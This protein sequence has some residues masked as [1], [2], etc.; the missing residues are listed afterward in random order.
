[1]GYLGLRP[2]AP[3]LL[4]GLRR[5]EYRGYDSAG[6]AV[7]D[8]A[9]DLRISKRVGKLETLIA[10]LQGETPEGSV[11]VGHPRWATHGRPSDDNAHPHLD[12]TGAVVVIH[13]G[14][15]ENYLS[16][17]RD[18]Q[19][20]GH[21]FTSETDT[22]VIPH[23]IECRLAGGDDLPAAVRAAIERLEGAHAIVVMSQRFP[24]ALVAAR[25]GNA[26]G[27]VVGYGDGDMFVASDLPALLPHT[28]RVVFLADGEVAAVARDGPSYWSRGG[29]ALAREPQAVPY[30]PMAAARGV[31]KHFLL[32]EIMEQP[33]AVLDTFR[34]RALFEP[35]AVEL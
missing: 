13:N 33:E 18:L 9:G 10:S 31:Y 23:L 29:E 27:V 34:G 8:A 17:K 6:I 21:R 14:I 35:P 3:I 28:R 11:G 7:L 26:G 24:D 20:Q 30:D 2:A 19:A 15:V 25:V 4:D 12:C 5:L 32:Q 22:E 1:M 16:L